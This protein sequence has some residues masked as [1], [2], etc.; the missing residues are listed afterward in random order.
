MPVMSKRR[1]TWSVR[2]QR[3]IP[4][5][6]PLPRSASIR[7]QVLTM[8]AIPVESMN[9]QSEK[10]INR[11]ATPELLAPSSSSSSVGAVLRS[12]SP[13]MEITH[14]PSCMSRCTSKGAGFNVAFS[15]GVGTTHQIQPQ[16]AS[17]LIAGGPPRRPPSPSLTPRRRSA[18]GFAPGYGA[19]F[20]TRASGNVQFARQF[21][22]ESFPR[23]NAAAG[24][25]ARAR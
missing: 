11:R 24:P 8:S 9:S 7:C 3:T 17:N 10:S 16:S 2:Q 12:S 13:L 5:G 14:T 1:L 19:E 15:S 4:L 18:R 25:V 23:Q 21:Q 22:T 6:L 20:G